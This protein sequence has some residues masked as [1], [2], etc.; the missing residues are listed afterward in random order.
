[1]PSPLPPLS[2]TERG[3][4]SESDLAE[5][6]PGDAEPGRPGGPFEVEDGMADHSMSP[7]TV[8]SSIRGPYCSSGRQSPGGGSCSGGRGAVV[9]HACPVLA[10][11]QPFA[12][13]GQLSAHSLP[14]GG[15]VQGVASRQASGQVQQPGRRPDRLRGQQ[16]CW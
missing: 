8:T 14:A 16:G 7:V 3:V 15:D 1:V 5:Q 4:E 10:A 6:P 2:L 13:Q 11:G 9:Q 12:H